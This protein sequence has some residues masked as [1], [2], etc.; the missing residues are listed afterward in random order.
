MEDEIK[1]NNKFEYLIQTIANDQVELGR[2]KSLFIDLEARIDNLA[3]LINLKSIELCKSDYENLL[4]LSHVINNKIVRPVEGKEIEFMKAKSLFEKCKEEK[5]SSVRE[6]HGYYKNLRNL[7]N[8]SSEV[9]FE[10]CKNELRQRKQEDFARKCLSSCFRYMNIN[11]NT[12][13]NLVMKETES[14]EDKL[15][16]I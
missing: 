1:F 16:K 11:L 13:C 14:A 10:Q 6:L 4:N 15:N 5:E 3:R 7:S 8:K 12:A 9:C 2:S